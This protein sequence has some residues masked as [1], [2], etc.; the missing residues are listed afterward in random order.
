M[1]KG[2]AFFDSFS[3]T[4]RATA[5]QCLVSTAAAED[6]HLH[7]VDFEQVFIRG[8]WAALPEGAPTCFIRPPSGWDGAAALGPGAVLELCAPLYGHPARCLFFTLNEFMTDLG[9]VK[10]GFDESV[11][12]VVGVHIDDSLIACR[13]LNEL[14]ALKRLLLERFKGTNG[15]EVT[16]YLGCAL[17]PHLA[18]IRRGSLAPS[19]STP[20]EPGKRLTKKASPTHPN[21][22]LQARFRGILGHT[23]FLVQMTRPD[24]SF[25]FAELSKFA[26]CPG[27]KHLDSAERMLRYIAGTYNQGITYSGTK[28]RNVLMG[29]VDSDFAADPDT[30]RSVTGYIISMNNGPVSWKAKRQGCV[31]LSSAEAEFVAASQCCQEV[32]YLRHSLEHLG[33]EHHEPTRIYEDNEACIKMSENPTNPGASR[34]IDTHIYFIQELVIVRDQVLRLHKISFSLNAADALTKSLPALA[35]HKHRQYLFGGHVPFEAFYTS[36]LRINAAKMA[37]AA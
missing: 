21:P 7:T 15:G 30:R 3:S 26:A 33:Y 16:E 11:W 8:D 34:H 35:F 20:L 1:E 22:V 18:A 24:L 13:N 5:M 17:V 19:Y 32:L 36:V 14:E 2:D 12:I 23:S 28:R 31:T 27:Q 25:A 4:P 29:W 37:A 6:M 9:F 10:A